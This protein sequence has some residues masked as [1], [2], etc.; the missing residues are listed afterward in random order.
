MELNK[1]ELDTLTGALRHR[2]KRRVFFWVT[3]V[4]AIGLYA[5]LTYAVEPL[6]FEK[7]EFAEGLLLGAIVATCLAWQVGWTDRER[8]DELIKIILRFVN[9][10]SEAM[11]Q[12]SAKHG[13]GNIEV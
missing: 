4:L 7:F 2:K 8:E 13:L 6:E 1:E 11:E 9:H 3:T 12:L 10:D 5:M